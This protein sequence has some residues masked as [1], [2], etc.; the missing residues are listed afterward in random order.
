MRR[1][2]KVMI[3]LCLKNKMEDFLGG[4]IVRSKLL[5]SALFSIVMSDFSDHFKVVEVKNT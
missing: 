2:Y 5:Y 3:E 1:L 4:L